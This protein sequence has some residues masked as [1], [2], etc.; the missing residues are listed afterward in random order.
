M[1]IIPLSDDPINEAK[2]FGF[3]ELSDKLTEFV[4]SERTITP[5]VIAINGEWGS[6][7]SSILLT[8]MKKLQGKLESAS[9][10]LKVV[11]F[12]AWQYESSNPAAALVYRMIEPIQSTKVSNAMNIAYLVVDLVARNSLNMSLSDM[13]N[14]FKNS[15]QAVD[16]LGD[17][18]QKT[19]NE[20]LPKGRLIVLI[21]DLDRCTIDNALSILNSIKLFL[22]MKQCLFVIAVDMKKLELAWKAR[23]GIDKELT[24]E[25]TSYLDK[26]FQMRIGVPPKT[27][28]ELKKYIKGLIPEI[29]DELATFVSKI[30]PK[31][32]RKI[33]RL[34]NIAS[35]H[36]FGGKAKVRKF[37][38]AIIWVI[39]E[40]ILHNKFYAIAVFNQIKNESGY[41]FLTTVNEKIPTDPDSFS[42]Y[43]NTAQPFAKYGGAGS[44]RGSFR[45]YCIEVRKVLSLFKES[46]TELN[47]SLSEIVK[48]SEEAQEEMDYGDWV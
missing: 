29:S 46:H 9:I 3:D 39:F 26:I 48:S 10:K 25:G 30:G 32:L 15:I 47:E 6:G 34:L 27:S 18:I 42:K 14:H 19:L 44:V 41:D 12:D 28:E 11:Y 38:L 45:E 35:F 31:N 17:Y 2:L 37:E 16:T 5:F 1:N 8:T 43:L 22:S 36:A 40:Y 7:K 23:Y 21:D 24:T 13:K 33:K 20:K 4:M